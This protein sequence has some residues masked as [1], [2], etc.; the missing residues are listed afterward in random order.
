MSLP[1]VSES[2]DDA[3]SLTLHELLVTDCAFCVDK[4]I[5]EPLFE[6]EK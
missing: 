2:D 3:E 6:T 1:G 5:P 4:L